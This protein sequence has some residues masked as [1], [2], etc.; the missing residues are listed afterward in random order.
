MCIR[1]SNF[2]VDLDLDAAGN[3]TYCAV[4]SIFPALLALLT[5][6]SL[7]GEQQ[8]TARWLLEMA[9]KYLSADVVELLRDPITRLTQAQHAGWVLVVS[10]LLALGGQRLRQRIRTRH[11]P[12]LRR[13]RGASNLESHPLQPD[14]DRRHPGH[15]GRDAAGDG[16]VE[17]A[18][19]CLLYTSRCV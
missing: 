8:A 5:L 14:A 16:D 9:T 17:Q 11:E 7:V 4:L 18:D 19:P 6:L 1:D 10:L 2:V 12:R 15:R 3:L 13:R